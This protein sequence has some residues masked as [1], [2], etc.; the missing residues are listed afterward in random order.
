M[1][2]VNVTL[3]DVLRAHDTRA[4]AQRRLLRTY[5]LPLVSFTM[6]I[7]GPV[8]SS[9]LIALAFDTGLEALYDALGQPMAAEIIRPATGCEALLVYD[10]PAAELKAA[11]L[12]LETAT[13]VGRLYDL[14][15]LDTDGDKLSRLVQRTCLICGGPVTVCSRN[16]EPHPRNS[17][18]LRRRIFG[19]PGGKGTDGGG[20]TD[21]EAGTDRRTQ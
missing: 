2:I 1:P 5:R 17:D 4:D 14:D 10:R 15:V 21:P 7:A 9:P 18:G 8:K 6:N 11:C 3:E 19:R 20:A 16:C 12:A 13:P